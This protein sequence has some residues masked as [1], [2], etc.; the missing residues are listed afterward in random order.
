MAITRT[1]KEAVVEKLKSIFADAQTIVFVQFN[2]VTAEEA[3][4]LRGV[5]ADEKVGYMVAKKTLIKKAFKN[6][7]IEGDL[8]EMEGEIALAYGTDILTPARVMGE[9][10]KN[11]EDR[12][13]IV[14][15]VFENAPVLQEQM[16]AIAD[17]PPLKTLYTQF[18]TIIRVPIQGFAS[19]LSQVADTKE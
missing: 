4:A 11:L 1:K 16:Q 15:G 13:R 18:L 19:V 9:Q 12:L 2:Q 7:G 8:P 17:I 3:S 14:G 6:S 5:C 10:G